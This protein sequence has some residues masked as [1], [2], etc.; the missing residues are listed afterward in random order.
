M[1]MLKDYQWKKLNVVVIFTWSNCQKSQLCWI[2]FYEKKITCVVKKKNTITI[3]EKCYLY[4]IIFLLF[5]HDNFN[6]MCYLIQQKCI[7]LFFLLYFKYFDTFQIFVLLKFVVDFFS[8]YSIFFH[9]LILYLSF[10]V[11]R[12]F[13]HQCTVRFFNCTR[14]HVCSKKCQYF[15]M[16]LCIK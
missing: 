1:Q 6:E 9:I 12:L 2:F 3:P 4:L 13:Y 10:F 8:I 7:Y 11:K 5:H 14:W 16:K 15:F